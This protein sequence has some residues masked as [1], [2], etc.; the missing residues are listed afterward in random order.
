MAQTTDYTHDVFLSYNQAQLDWAENLA[1]RLREAGVRVWFDKWSLRPGEPWLVGLERGIEGSRHFAFVASPQWLDAAWPDLEAQIAVLC[2]PAARNRKIIPLLYASCELPK[3]L[4]NRQGI[5]FTDTHADPERYAWRLAQLLAALDASR[6]YPEDFEPFRRGL[7][8][9][10]PQALPPPRAL[11]PGSRMPLPYNPLFVGREEELRTLARW[12]LDEGQTAAIGQVAAATGLGGIG[13]TQLAA[14]FVH[15]YGRRF[16]GGVFWLDL[17]QPE[18]VAEQVAECGGPGRMNLTGWSEWKQPEQV[19]AVQGEWEKPVSRL[20][21]FD[22]VETPELVE[23]WKPRAGGA[24]VLVTSRCADWPPSTGVRALPLATLPRPHS[25]ELLCR[26]LGHAGQ[27]GGC[28]ACRQEPQHSALDGICDTLGDLPL[29]LHLAASYLHTYRHSTT[30]VAYLAALRA[31]PVLHNPALVGAVRDPSPTR[32][33]QNVA[34]TFQVSYDR[35]DA[36]Q[37]TD[38]LARQAFALL[39]HFAPGTSVPRE[40]LQAALARAGGAPERPQASALD[41]ALRRLRDLGLLELDESGAPYLHRLL[42]EFAR[43]CPEAA[44]LAEAVWRAVADATDAVNGGGLPARMAPLLPHLRHVAAQADGGGGE[45]AGWLWNSLGYHLHVVAEYTAAHQAHEEALRVHEAT[46][47]PQHP[48]VARDVNNLGG[49]LQEQGDLAG[50]RRAFERALHIDEAAF[51]AECPDVARDVNNLGSVLQ[52]QGDLTGARQCF[53]RALGIW[54]EAVGSEHPQVASALNNLGNVLQDQGDLAGAR[55]CYERALRIDE[56]AFGPEHPKEAICVN[57]LGSVL[58]D[59]GDLAGARRAFE[60]ALRINEAAFGPE[61][62]QVA[63][64]VNN[65]GSVLQQQGDLAGAR[66]AFER[67]LRIFDKAL[68][69]EH[70]NV[71][72]ALNNLGNVLQ[73]Q[74]DLAGARQ[75]YERALRIDEAAFGPE[76]PAMATDVNNLGSVLQDQGDLAGARRAYERALRIDEAAFGAEHPDVARDVNNL[77]SVLREQGDLAGAR[78]AYEHT[79]RIFERVYS[80]DHPKTRTVRENLQGLATQEPPIPTGTD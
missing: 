42:A 76:H 2:D 14:A 25:L 73:D 12:L 66:K 62:P 10:D 67:V 69:P 53:E 63:A 7:P 19:R 26:G 32:H 30:P 57:N 64:A 36:N 80:P 28:D 43:L 58:Q 65:L 29:A 35:L 8:G 16:P 5:D 1:R 77:G 48:E 4:A 44:G 31:Q 41:E 59:Q 39:G 3:R 23:Q 18:A 27:P 9:W 78:Q 54:G 61:H 21:V 38:A 71:A 47:G 17:S 46:F 72:S 52:Q 49:V 15:R 56:A 68:G 37:P 13:K 79:L 55:Q 33:V 74:G 24:R 40:L 50:A 60:R 70:P 51:G 20:L 6:D 11:P 45:L 75:C 34:A 22:N